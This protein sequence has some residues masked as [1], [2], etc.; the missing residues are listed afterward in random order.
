MK[1]FYFVFIFLFLFIFFTLKFFG[2]RFNYTESMPIGF[3]KKV[4]SV[5]IARNDLVAV[6][7]PN[8]I[9]LEG[10]K[11]HYLIHGSCSNGSTPVLKKIIAVPGD[12][13][14]LN[15]QMM[16]VNDISFIAPLQLK[17][18]SHQLI[19]KFI[20]NGEHK[21]I[22]SYWLYGINDPTYSWDS[23]YYGGVDCKNIIGVYKPVLTL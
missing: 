14:S 5:H 9:A 22:D 6:C 1:K 3:Y 18:S 11:R 10:L 21:N 23:R 13:V 12:T 7:L 8:R 4:H 20:K 17:D 2:I 15:N 16:I 19:K